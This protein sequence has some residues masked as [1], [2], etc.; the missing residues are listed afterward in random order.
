M[1]RLY[2]LRTSLMAALFALCLAGCQ[3][4]E[5]FSLLD[6]NN[7]IVG[8]GVLEITTS[9]PSSAHLILSRFT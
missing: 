4:Q 9:F 8:K 5:D 2:K 1:A 6:D 3:G 7:N